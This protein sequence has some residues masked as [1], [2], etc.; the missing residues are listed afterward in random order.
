MNLVII[1]LIILDAWT[2]TLM[3]KKL[4]ATLVPKNYITETDDLVCDESS[5]K[6]RLDDAMLKFDKLYNDTLQSFR[7]EN[8]DLREFVDFTD[9]LMTET[10]DEYAKVSGMSEYVE[11]VRNKWFDS[12]PVLL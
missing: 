6:S 10:F 1:L 3:L 9:K 12:R 2:D 4:T 5:L 7:K 11:Q 8:R